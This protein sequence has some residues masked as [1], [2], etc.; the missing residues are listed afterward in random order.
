[1][2]NLLGH[3][4]ALPRNLIVMLITAYQHTLSPDHGPL[5]SLHPYGRCRHSPTCSQYAK[6][7]IGERGAM[8]GG[9]FAMKRLL[10][11]HPWRKLDETRIMEITAMRE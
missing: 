7:Q 1:M 10:S 6:E 2:R 9:M 11:C 5:R 4:I 8:V 3:I